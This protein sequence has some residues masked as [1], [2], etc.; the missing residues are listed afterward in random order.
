[1]IPLNSLL[2]SNFPTITGGRVGV[3]SGVGV[4][5][6]LRDDLLGVF[7]DPAV[8]G[9][10]AG[11]D[12][13]EGKRT[14]LIAEAFDHARQQGDHEATALL[15]SV[16]GD[17]D[18]DAERLRRTRDALVRLGAVSAV[19]D[20]ITTLTSAALAAL[21]TTTL[22]EPAATRLGELALVVTDRTS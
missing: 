5:F 6:Q 11:D 20:R 1:M 7:G 14:L 9:K 4:A 3:G 15:E 8:T 13:R 17:P 22:A 2:V 10:P 18:L 19:E 12:L 21:S 16:L